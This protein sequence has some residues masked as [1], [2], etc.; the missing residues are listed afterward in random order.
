MRTISARYAATLRNGSLEGTAIVPDAPGLYFARAT[1]R[2][3]ATNARV[4]VSR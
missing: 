1:T 2:T 3:A 4:V